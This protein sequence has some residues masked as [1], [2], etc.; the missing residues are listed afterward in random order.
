M[1]KKPDYYEVLGIAKTASVDQIKAAYRTASLKYHPDRMRNKSEAEKKEGAEKFQLATEAHKVLT[2]GSLRATY[3]QYGHQG[4]ENAKNGSGNNQSYSDAAGPLPVKKP[5]SEG[6]L[7]DFFEKRKGT[8]K[9]STTT[10]TDS[11]GLTAEERRKRAAE[12]RI[13]NRGKK[14]SETTS[15]TETFNE[16]AEKLSDA[17][18]SL[19]DA[20]VSIDD[21]Q[22]IR[23]KAAELLKEVDAALVRARK[24]NGPKP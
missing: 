7:F 16:T 10:T 3:D 18:E 20:D 23:D 8:N 19:K 17:T 15:T 11:D 24:N 14:S 5:A 4:V 12:E 13:K 6:D 21:L 2:D 1:S 22:R 9:T